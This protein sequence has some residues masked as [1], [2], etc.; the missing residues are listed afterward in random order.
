MMGFD[1]FGG[2]TEINETAKTVTH[3]SKYQK[4]KLY[5]HYRKAT[6]SKKCGNCANHIGGGYH[7]KQYHKCKL[8][9]VSHSIAT[10]IRISC[11]CDAHKYSANYLNKLKGLE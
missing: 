11:V 3:M 2:E 6:D 9:G 1:L 7:E 8:I 5:Y 10:D 4:T